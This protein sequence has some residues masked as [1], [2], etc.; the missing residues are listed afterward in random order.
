MSCNGMTTWYEF[1]RKIM[2]LV[3]RPTKVRAVGN[4]YFRKD[5][6][7]PENTYLINRKL[8]EIGLDLMPTWEAALSDYLEGKGYDIHRD[9]GLAGW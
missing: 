4:D 1:A 8:T 9:Q 3:G 6:K 2:E 5:F 7:R